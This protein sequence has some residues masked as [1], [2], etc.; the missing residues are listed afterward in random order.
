[1]PDQ[2]NDFLSF[3]SPLVLC[4]LWARSCLCNCKLSNSH[5]ESVMSLSDVRFFHSVHF[6]GDNGS[7]FDNA[8]FFLVSFSLFLSSSHFIFF[9]Q[10][11]YS[12]G[13]VNQEKTSKITLQTSPYL[14][15]RNSD[16]RLLV[17]AR[18]IFNLIGLAT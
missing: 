2:Y 11:S 13:G 12:T 8:R 6:T 18:K 9:F 17:F 4:L 14:Y 3:V 1:M 15:I 5:A 10:S 16:M 7:F